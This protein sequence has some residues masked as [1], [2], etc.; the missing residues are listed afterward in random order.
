MTQSPATPLPSPEERRR[1]REAKSLTQA[2][3]AAALGVPQETVRAWESG[4]ATPEGPAG[5]AY[6][7][8]LASSTAA[9][10]S[11]PLGERVRHAERV[12]RG[13][14]VRPGERGERVQPGERGERVQPSE[15]LSEPPEALPG[16]GGRGAA[17]FRPVDDAHPADAFD[18]L[19]AHSA[20]ALVGQAYLLTG[21]RRLAQE[22]VERAFQH[23]W[24]RWPEVAVDRDPAGWVRAAVHEYAMSPWHRFRPGLRHPDA[25][26]AEPADRALFRVLM[27]L[28]PAQ[29]RTLVLYDGVG[30]D[31]PD[32]AAETQAST[33]ATAYRLM[34]ARESVAEA[35]PDLAAPEELHRR[36]GELATAA[37][38][39]P[40]EPE[41]VR[42]R[43]EHRTR[44]WTRAAIAFT[45]L[46]IGATSLTLRTAPTRY[47]APVAP[48]KAVTGIPAYMGPA[49]LT[50]RSR[51]LH[52][53]LDA[54]LSTGPGRLTPG[55]G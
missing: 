23:A 13:E 8:L 12:R 21:R 46:I 24:Q 35:L 4:R 29:R 36:L 14:R 47:E 39:P 38:L 15:P 54:Q 28:P 10:T 31:L 9:R 34:H 16:P 51:A 11:G 26:P 5:K 41:H 33:P 44:V 3:L 1:L 30:L 50:N 32:T 22:S 48:G 40:P 27:A 19:C 20:A 18:A 2:E 42:L 45:A 52:T 25:P 17:A 6:A 37:E 7:K 43:G 53:H 55:L 49:P